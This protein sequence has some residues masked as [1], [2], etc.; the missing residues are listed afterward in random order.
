MLPLHLG[1]GLE[2][3]EL[4]EFVPGV[5]ETGRGAWPLGAAWRVTAAI[6]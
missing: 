1:D 3:S 5:E 6:F 2:F 4:P